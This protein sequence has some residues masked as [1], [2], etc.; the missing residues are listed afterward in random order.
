MNRRGIGLA[1]MVVALTLSVAMALLAWSIL[2]VSAGKLRE[3]SERMGLAHALRVSAGAFRDLAEPLGWDST[4]AADLAALS[5]DGLSARVIR[6]AGTLCRV[7]P[8]GVLVRAGTGWWT[9]VRAAVAGRDSVLIGRLVDPLGWIAADLAGTPGGATCPDGSAAM[10]LPLALGASDAAAI[11]PG[12]PVRV[13]EPVELRRYASGAGSWI[14]ARL[15]AT[16]EAIQPLAGPLAGTG[17]WL[18]GR[19]IGG[20][21]V[22]ALGEVA[23]LVVGLRGVTERAMGVGI[24]RGGVVGTDSVEFSILLRNVR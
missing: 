16:G 19:G 23:M 22:A 17:V 14:G 6:A 3:R 4:G 8:S 12:S 20:G 7:M 18:S 21:A 9:A 11:G 13:I 5:S 2:A 24:A 1:E 15:V 10:L